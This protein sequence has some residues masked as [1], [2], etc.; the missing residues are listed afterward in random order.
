MKYRIIQDQDSI[1]IL[2]E[3]GGVATI[4][5]IESGYRTEYYQNRIDES[6][7]SDDIWEVLA[8]GEMYISDDWTDPSVNV[9][10]LI[11]EA[12]AW[13]VFPSPQE[14]WERDDTIWSNI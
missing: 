10:M 2:V 14:G 3:D 5:F 7:G 9:E 12:L 13:L 6:V 1:T 4:D 8:E 11:Q